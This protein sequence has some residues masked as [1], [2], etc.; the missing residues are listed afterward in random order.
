MD[1]AFVVNLHGFVGFL[2]FWWLCVCAQIQ[3]NVAVCHKFM[4]QLQRPLT[5]PPRVK[6]VEKVRQQDVSDFETAIEAATER[7]GNFEGGD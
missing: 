7:I 2:L 4:V 1:F 3:P 5:G 6:K